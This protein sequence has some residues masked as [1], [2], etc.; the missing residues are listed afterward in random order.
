MPA[1]RRGSELRC[2]PQWPPASTWAASPARAA[3]PAGAERVTRV[4][5]SLFR[6]GSDPARSNSGMRHARIDR[7]RAAQAKDILQRLGGAK[8]ARFAAWR[9][10]D[11]QADRQVLIGETAG[12]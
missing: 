2:R 5:T 6:P 9:T 8:D 3:C 12:K 7:R 11:L 10:G 4:Q 1:N